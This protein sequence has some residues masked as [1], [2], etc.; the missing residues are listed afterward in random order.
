M[1]AQLWRSLCAREPCRHQSKAAAPGCV[2]GARVPCG[3][4]GGPCGEPGAVWGA[5]RLRSG[6]LG[7]A[8]VLKDVCELGDR[9]GSAR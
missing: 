5:A 1:L 3:E 7:R 8:L 9:G 4:L 6:M 2:R